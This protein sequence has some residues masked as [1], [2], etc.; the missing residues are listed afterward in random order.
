MLSFARIGFH[1]PGLGTW[2]GYSLPFLDE[3]AGQR[4]ATLGGLALVSGV[5]SDLTYGWVAEPY[6]VLPGIYFGLVL[7]VGLAFWATH[8]PLKLAIAFAASNL[9][10]W[11]AFQAALFLYPY[12]EDL[13][14]V[15]AILC[16]AASG[17]IGALVTAAA[18]AYACP[19]FATR[20]NWIRTLVAG[21]LAGVLLQG[22][23][24]GAGTQLPLLLV[25]QAA[26]AASIGYGLVNSERQ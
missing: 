10:W 24:I 16:G 2:H 26:V 15:P 25:W 13:T 4:A 14:S 9:A 3:S 22:I 6:P 8:S 12:A 19:G 5:L 7:V 18:A 17:V 21:G 20:E 1:A 23:D 11:G